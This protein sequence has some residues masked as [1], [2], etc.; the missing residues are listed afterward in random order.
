M[1][2]CC[3][4]KGSSGKAPP[5]EFMDRFITIILR[6]RSE[7]LFIFGT[8]ETR[9]KVLLLLRLVHGQRGRKGDAELQD[10]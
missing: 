4:G 7:L 6:S 10:Y 1:S 2:F 3:G 5:G 8:A 9:R